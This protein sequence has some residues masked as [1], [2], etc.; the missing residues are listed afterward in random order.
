MIDHFITSPLKKSYN[1]YNLHN[2]NAMIEPTRPTG[3]NETK[4]SKKEI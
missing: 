3:T 4:Y 1:I 2:R